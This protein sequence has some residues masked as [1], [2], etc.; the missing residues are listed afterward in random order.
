M[1]GLSYRAKRLTVLRCREYIIIYVWTILECHVSNFSSPIRS[2]TSD[3]RGRAYI[4]SYVRV[5]R[6]G[7]L[8]YNSFRWRAIRLFNQ[9]PLFLRNTT[10]CSVYSFKIFFIYLQRL[11]LHASQDLTTWRLFEMADTRDGLTDK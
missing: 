9:L 5:G 1:Q 11:V 3:R 2:R 10:V 7:T 4:T 8:A 6:L